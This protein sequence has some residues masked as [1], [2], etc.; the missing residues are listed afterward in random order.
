M[1]HRKAPHAA[2]DTSAP[3]SEWGCTSGVALGA[4]AF[5]QQEGSVPAVSKSGHLRKQSS[6]D[7]R[8]SEVSDRLAPTGV[9]AACRTGLAPRRS[10]VRRHVSVVLVQVFRS[11]GRSM[12]EWAGVF[13]LCLTLNANSLQEAANFQVFDVLQVS[14]LRRTLPQLSAQAPN[15]DLRWRAYGRSAAGR[16]I[17]SRCHDESRPDPSR[18]KQPARRF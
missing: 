1:Q 3:S 14:G 7:Q 16:E 11:G 4:R 15:A 13:H 17:E 2:I 5:D 9:S 18:A 12:T 6:I 8:G 10:R